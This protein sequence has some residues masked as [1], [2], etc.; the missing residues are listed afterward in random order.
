MLSAPARLTAAL[1]RVV[2]HRMFAPFAS[3]RTAGCLVLPS[4]VLVA[5]CSGGQTKPTELDPIEFKV[6]RQGGQPA[7]VFVRDYKKLS[8][9]ALAHFNAHEW[10]EALRLFDIA[11]REF[12][13]EAGLFA[14]QYN[15][16][17]CLM[18]LQRPLQAVPRFQDALKRSAGTR[19]ARDALFQIADA[20]ELAEKWAEAA[21]TL[22]SALEDPAVQQQIGGPLGLL[23]ELEAWARL[24]IDLAKA[25]ELPKADEAFKRVERIY[26]DN[27]DVSV[28]GES[29]WV[30]RSLYE[31]GEIYRGLFASIRFKLPVD[32]MKRD[33]EDKANLFL[34]GESA[35]FHCVRLHHKKWS[36]AAGYEIG[37]LYQ[38]LIDDIDHAEVPPELDAL[39]V[40]V[41][42]D[43]LWNHTEH[44]AKRAVTIY[45]KN[46]ELAQRLGEHDSDWVKRSEAGMVRMEQ[47]IEFAN[48]RRRRLLLKGAPVV[49]KVEVVSP[50]ASPTATTTEP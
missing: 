48:A 13:Q 26:N 40:D 12:P 7:K 3:F 17:L 35:Y 10:A 44:L 21:A 8:E 29:A 38:Q 15:A 4:L 34:K 14:L 24:G 36:L 20:Y 43:E 28:I 47:M 33:L 37:H 6:D 9:E 32:R 41:Y 25:G 18:Q 39:T 23:D 16:G 1:G 30:A 27:R 19:N 22:R 5:G 49:P 11:V 2:L 50:P 45:K 42:R 46:V 31:R